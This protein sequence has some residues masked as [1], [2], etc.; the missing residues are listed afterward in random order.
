[1][2]KRKNLYV[3]LGAVGALI[4]LL[5]GLGGTSA[6]SAQEGTPESG[7]APTRGIWDWGRGMFGFGRGGEWTMFDTT[8][9]AL[10]LTPEELFSRLH[11]GKSL[12]EV[13]EERGVELD[14]VQEALNAARDEALR[15][16]IEQAVENGDLSREHANWL[17]E[18]LEQGYTLGRGF[19]HGF[20]HGWRGPGMRG[21]FGGFAP[22][23]IT[24]QSKSSDTWTPVLPGSSSL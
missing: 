16:A 13:A 8:A 7:D 19:G 20:G 11:D 24:P 12:K 14:A 2:L 21:G 1:M 9:E 4:L 10:D 18:G 3:A 15:D 6:V 5:G 23:G 22:G 17:L